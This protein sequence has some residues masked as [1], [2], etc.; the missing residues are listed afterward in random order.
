VPHRTALALTIAA[1]IWLLTLVAAP[2]AAKQGAFALPAASVYAF[3]SR[4]CHQLPER[5]FDLGGIQLPVCARCFGLY[6]SGAIGALAAWSSRRRAG[7]GVRIALAVA[8]IPT[9]VTWS[10]EMAGLAAFSNV[11]RAAA[12][13]PLGAVAGWVFVQMLRYDSSLDGHQ[14]HDSRSR[15]H[16]R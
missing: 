8:A 14:V 12:A 16:S 1:S 2:V 5:S 10:A 13:L 15:V 3:S 6:L 9:A 4:I 7:G 11:S